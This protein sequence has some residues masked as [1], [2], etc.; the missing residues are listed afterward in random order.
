ME[1]RVVQFTAQLSRGDNSKT[2]AEQMQAII[3]DHLAAGWDY[4]RMDTVQAYIAGSSGCFGVG[5][6]PGRIATYNVLVFSRS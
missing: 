5:A 6:E 3:D 1:Y 4:Y 2:V